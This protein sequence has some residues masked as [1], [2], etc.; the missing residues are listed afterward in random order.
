MI[1]FNLLPFEKV[2][3]QDELTEGMHYTGADLKC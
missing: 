2:T 1:V 3:L